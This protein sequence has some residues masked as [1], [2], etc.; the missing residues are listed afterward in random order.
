MQ[1]LIGKHALLL[2]HL[3]EFHQSYLLFGQVSR[4]LFRYYK[5]VA[6]TGPEEKNSKGLSR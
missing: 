6:S 1:Q 3:D 4:V 5:P 2:H